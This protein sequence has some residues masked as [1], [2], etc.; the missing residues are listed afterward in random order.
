MTH[1]YHASMDSKHRPEDMIKFYQFAVRPAA[2]IGWR[3]VWQSVIEYVIFIS[4][5]AL[6][7]N[8]L[9]RRLREEFRFVE[10]GDSH[11]GERLDR[12]VQDGVLNSDRAGYSLSPRGAAAVETRR[13]ANLATVRNFIE[14][15][16]ASIEKRRISLSASDRRAVTR[17][18]YRFITRFSESRTTAS[19][20]QIRS[21][22]KSVLPH[23]LLAYV[24]RST[25]EFRAK[26]Q[27]NLADA[28]LSAVEECVGQDHF[29]G[30]LWCMIQLYI[31]VELLRLNP[32][33]TSIKQRLFDACRV[34]LD[35]NILHDLLLPTREGH[36]VVSTLM[37]QMIGLSITPVVTDE[38]LREW[39]TRVQ[40]AIH[41]REGDTQSQIARSN[42]FIV[43]HASE[44]M[45]NKI[46]WDEY[47]ANL[48]SSKLK[49]RLQQLGIELIAPDW[50]ALQHNN[51]EEYQLL[52]TAIDTAWESLWK[53][54]KSPEQ[55]THDARHLLFVEA[56]RSSSREIKSKCWFLSRDISVN[57]VSQSLKSRGA[58]PPLSVLPDVWLQTLSVFPCKV[59][60]EATGTAEVMTEFLSSN[61]YYAFDVLSPELLDSLELASSDVCLDEED[62]LKLVA[63]AVVDMRINYPQAAD[64]NSD[65]SAREKVLDQ[66]IYDVQNAVVSSL[67]SQNSRMLT[68]LQEMQSRKGSRDVVLTVM[69]LGSA[70]MLARLLL[71]SGI[72]VLYNHQALWLVAIGLGSLATIAMI[73]KDSREA[74]LAVFRRKPTGDPQDTNGTDV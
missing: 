20:A 30:F 32:S 41:I 72:P 17:A 50:S 69:A 65:L 36:S 67:H 19:L 57:V 47:I 48:T 27:Q 21:D 56:E 53:G 58:Q 26:D 28:Y 22:P 70:I 11:L 18:I 62:P 64:L 29:V 52:H 59:G 51:Q 46:G 1:S 15:V 68:D 61:W 8:A 4:D 38:T 71:L 9:R 2:D 44:V 40:R 14:Q 49:I 7:E 33:G 45:T 5:T 10:L 73:W 66:I 12:L 42:A 34:L 43:D 54:K 60:C 24:V 35:T 55:V 39:E 63:D 6:S 37:K 23:A 74:C 3:S 16:C 13:A 31:T 25:C